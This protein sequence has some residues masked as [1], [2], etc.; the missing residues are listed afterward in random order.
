[1]HG[2]FVGEGMLTAAISG[3]TFASPSIDASRAI[4]CWFLAYHVVCRRPVSYSWS[5]VQYAGSGCHR[6]GYWLKRQLAHHQ[7]LH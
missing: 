7:E 1:M 5:S 2:G 4:C 3:E 6:P